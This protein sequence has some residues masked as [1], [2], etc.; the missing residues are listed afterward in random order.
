VAVSVNLSARE[1]QQAR[2]RV[3]DQVSSVLST[4]GLPAGS[5]TLE[6][7]ESAVMQDAD[8][9]LATMRDLK[10][11]GVRLALDDFGSG[12]SSLSYLHRL[13]LEEVKIDQSF[14]RELSSADA[15]GS[16][17]VGATVDL[18]HRLGFAVVAEGVES[19]DEWDRLISLGCD[20]VQGFHIAR[21]M[22][23]EDVLRWLDVLRA[24]PR[25]LAS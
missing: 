7:K 10:K 23:V 13:P 12:Y 8:A 16:T 25:A 19:R 20:I 2:L 15:S 14:I 3:I 6:I 1:L 9:A 11:L 24:T 4:S 22:P 5:L 18:G 17:I 21:P